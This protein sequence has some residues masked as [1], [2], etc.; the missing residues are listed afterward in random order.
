L[1]VTGTIEAKSVVNVTPS[2][3][4]LAGIRLLLD[5]LISEPEDHFHAWRI[6]ERDIPKL[7]DLYLSGS[8]TKRRG[9]SLSTVSAIF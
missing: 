1:G 7:W 9:R 6:T 2:L 4:G 5:D 8:G 3:L